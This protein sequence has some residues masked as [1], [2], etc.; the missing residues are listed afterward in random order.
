MAT[1]LDAEILIVGAGPAGLQWAT[2][3]ENAGVDYLL[4]E[5]SDNPAAFFRHYPRG[6]RL[7]SHNKCRVG[8]GRSAEFALRHDW[9]SLLGTNLS[10]CAFSA[11]YYPGAD[12]QNLGVQRRRHVARASVGR[13]TIGR[14]EFK[15]GGGTQLPRQA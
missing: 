3:L 11:A 12:D 1:P 13:C 8:R 15:A 7:I 2:L 9:H 10:M 5:A 4:L 6:R 14:A